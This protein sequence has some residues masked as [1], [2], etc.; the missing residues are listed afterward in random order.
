[1]QFGVPQTVPARKEIKPVCAVTCRGKVRT[2]LFQTF[3][4]AAITACGRHDGI[5]KPTV[6]VDILATFL[7]CVKMC[8]ALLP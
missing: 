1:M 4:L 3:L 6:Q 2:I 8:P 7:A 5:P